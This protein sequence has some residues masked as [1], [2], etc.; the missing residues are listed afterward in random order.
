MFSCPHCKKNGISFLDK[1]FCTN[2]SPA[3]CSYCKDES[4]YTISDAY[5]AAMFFF[6]TYIP[7]YV[8]DEDSL[9]WSYI[10]AGVFVI[11]RFTSK[12]RK[13]LT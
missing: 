2:Y 5:F 6:M 9:M 1:A 4:V 7:W 12:L 8:S 10:A 3:K 11:I 13:I